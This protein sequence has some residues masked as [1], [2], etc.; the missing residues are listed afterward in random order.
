M[1]MKTNLPFG[2]ST[3]QLLQTTG[4]LSIQQL[5]A[6]STLVTA[7]KSIVAQQPL[8]LAGKLKLRTDQPNHYVPNRQRNTIRNQSNLTIARSGFFCRSSA[9]FN[10]LPL[11][12]RSNMDPNIFKP[13][14][15]K[16]VK[17]NIPIKPG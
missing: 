3:L 1:R 16:W 9:L 15:K 10:Q 7:K 8:Y 6:C 17:Q 4:D 2:T 13:R 11:D 14:A 12:M 5:T